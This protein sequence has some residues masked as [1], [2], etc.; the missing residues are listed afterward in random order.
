MTSKQNTLGG[1]AS[2]PRC[3]LA[4]CE[5]VQQWMHHQEALRYMRYDI[6]IYIY[7][8]IYYIYLTQPNKISMKVDVATFEENLAKYTLPSL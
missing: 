3:G 7:Y 8:I 5:A 4:S 6:Y 2:G 1:W